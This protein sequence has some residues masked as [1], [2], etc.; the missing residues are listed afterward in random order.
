[1][2]KD[3]LQ[4]FRFSSFPRQRESSKLLER[5]DTR[6]HGYD[7]TLVYKRK[8]WIDEYSDRRPGLDGFLGGG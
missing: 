7:D 5:L 4:N 3:R 2:I 1:M 6:F 8:S